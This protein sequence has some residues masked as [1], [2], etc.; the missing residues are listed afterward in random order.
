M[1]KTYRERTVKTGLGE[2]RVYFGHGTE[3]AELSLASE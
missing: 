3:P 1:S 2:V